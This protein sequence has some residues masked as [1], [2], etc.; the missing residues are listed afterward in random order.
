MWRGQFYPY[1]A[2][3]EVVDDD[4]G[5]GAAAVVR[6]P[7]IVALGATRSKQ[8]QRYVLGGSVTEG[9]LGVGHASVF[10]FV[11]MRGALHPLAHLTADARG[12]FI[13]TG[14]LSVNTTV[15]FRATA[16]VASRLVMPP[17]CTA[18]NGWPC[19]S[20]TVSAWSKNSRVAVI[21]Q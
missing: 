7:H 21:R 12:R 14:R 16:R 11:G 10:L 1:N 9:G 17:H 2:A 20:K 4:A 18:I 13:Y 3:G 19:V 5:V 8:T 6:L 15:Q